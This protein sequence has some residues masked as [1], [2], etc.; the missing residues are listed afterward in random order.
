[1]WYHSS[2]IGQAFNVFSY[3]NKRVDELLDKGKTTLDREERKKIYHQFQR[4]IFVDPPGV[5]LFWR[6]YLIGIHKRFRGVKVS[7]A[8]ILSNINEWYVPKEE[9]KYR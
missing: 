7:P 5:F 1:M 6:D 3:R 2:Q 8:G 9:Q 4:E